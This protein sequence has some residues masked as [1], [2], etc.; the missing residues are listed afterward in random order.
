MVT[1]IAAGAV[2][3]AI[4]VVAIAAITGI[5][6]FF[7][8][9]RNRESAKVRDSQV[10]RETTL[11]IVGDPPEAVRTSQIVEP[12]APGARD[13]FCDDVERCFTKRGAQNCG[14]KGTFFLTF[15]SEPA[16]Y[17][18]DTSKFPLRRGLR[19][20]ASNVYFLEELH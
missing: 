14:N 2:G 5:C 7:D 19:R 6:F 15:E 3:A 18:H 17:V 20:E 4:A 1:I 9:K 8:S 11:R 12:T 10:H 16:H 13:V